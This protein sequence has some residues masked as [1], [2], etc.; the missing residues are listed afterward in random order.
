MDSEMQA[1]KLVVIGDSGVGKTSLRGQVSLFI[2]LPFFLCLVVWQRIL[3]RASWSMLTWWKLGFTLR[4]RK[5][6]RSHLLASTLLTE[7]VAEC[8][9]RILI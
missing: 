5:D 2:L 7:L 9:F 6:G 3:V 8:F 4:H 1:I